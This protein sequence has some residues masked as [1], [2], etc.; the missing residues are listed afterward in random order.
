MALSETTL[1]L[2]LQSVN[3]QAPKTSAPIGRLQKMTNACADQFEGQNLR[4]VQRTGFRQLPKKVI[5]PDSGTFW[6]Q[7]GGF[8]QPP[9][10][11]SSLERQLVA[12]AGN[13]PYV[14]AENAS[15]WART[16]RVIHTLSPRQRSVYTSNVQIKAP[17]S[18]CINNV[19]CFVW[20]EKDPTGHTRNYMCIRDV[21]GTMIVNPTQMGI[22]VT[23][24]VI[25]IKVISDGIKFWIF[26]SYGTAMQTNVYLADGTYVG[27]NLFATLKTL[28]GDGANW[29]DVQYNC[30]GVTWYGATSTVNEA[31]YTFIHSTGTVFPTLHSYNG[32]VGQPADRPFWLT[33]PGHPTRCY[34]GLAA[35]VDGVNTI[36]V[37]E[38]N[39]SGTW[40]RE[41][42]VQSGFSWTKMCQL[43]GHV[44]AAGNYN[45]LRGELGTSKDVFNLTV[46]SRTDV[47]DVT[48]LHTFN[49]VTP[50]SR[51]F[52]LEGR[53][54]SIMYFTDGEQPT[55]FLHDHA[56]ANDATSD[57][58]PCGMWSHGSSSADWQGASGTANNTNHDSCCVPSPYVDVLGNV[59]CAIAY[60]AET[61]SR[62]E[63]TYQRTGVNPITS[64]NSTKFVS[65]IGLA[66]IEW[67]K[68]GRA[69]EYADQ[70]TIPGTIATSFTGVLFSE[71]NFSLF[72]SPF[73]IAQSHSDAGNLDPDKDYSIVVVFESTDT[74]G[75][76]IK[77]RPSVPQIVT[78][79]GGNNIIT[80]TGPTLFETI[81]KSNVMISVYSTFIDDSG[82]ISTDHRKVTD[83]LSPVLNNMG[84]LTWS[85]ILNKTSA[86][87]Q[88]GEVLYTDNGLQPHDPCPAHSVGCIAGNRQFVYGYDGA[89]WFTD[90]KVEGEPLVYNV[91]SRRVL[92]PTSDTVRAMEA[93]DSMRVILLCERSIW[94]FDISQLPDP[95]GL[96]GN[97]Q[98][99]KK[100]PFTNGASAAI[101]TVVKEGIV[102]VSS[103]GGLPW[104]MTRGLENM[105]LSA[106]EY[107]D[108]LGQEINGMATND[109]QRTMFGL[110]KADN[111]QSIIRDGI[112]YSWADWL[113]PRKIN[114][115]H[116]F[117]GNFCY[118]D[119]I[120]VHYQ[121]ETPY[122][123]Y[124][125]DSTQDI[126]NAAIAQDIL[127][128]PV[129]FAGVKGLKC[130]WK[131]LLYGASAGAYNLLVDATYE[132][133]DGTFSE[134]WTIKAAQTSS[135]YPALELA[136]EPDTIEMSSIQIRLRSDY[137]GVPSPGKSF[138][139]ETI[140][141]EVGV[142]SHLNR[143]PSSRTP[144]ST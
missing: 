69:T 19:V 31:M 97:I 138:E 141:F 126:T 100:L 71:D 57:N 39:S 99:P 81:G 61:F 129:Y 76:R 87:I 1:D 96:N 85:F 42:V 40:L 10:L 30:L 110:N 66:D 136:F 54:T 86:D 4:T 114:L 93:L 94:E 14:L 91:D 49:S 130:V 104:L 117:N 73:T 95:T 137:T 88:V 26:H 56:D 70:L 143:T 140:S 74:R 32:I 7:T 12:I 67:S 131:F 144:S 28:P 79:T 36:T 59:H 101:S 108:F 139:L 83:D 62:N 120:S 63:V 44:D 13:N 109:K 17:D 52:L 2:H 60:L 18:A 77:S 33:N 41:S 123:T 121:D 119:D 89:V 127:T 3:Q 72:P 142:D 115:V 122:D 45:V 47:S 134:S 82:V 64:L 51:V 103:A 55:F 112:N 20:K 48:T 106:P 29:W 102:Y 46:R 35:T 68:P 105:Q 65:T 6:T 15:Q 50:A 11:L 135:V 111:F 16:S 80:I 78:L 75:N 118:A 116:T 9:K 37:E 21:D 107:A 113:H 24:D 92:I 132:T 58:Q 124:R 23:D 84:S 8:H 90:E 22:T 38:F 25:Q 43:S 53:F 128:A 27:F 98:S 5:N 34:L 133:E 125:D